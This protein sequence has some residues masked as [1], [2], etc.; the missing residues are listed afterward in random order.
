MT[1]KLLQTKTKNEVFLLEREGNVGTS[2][3]HPY[4]VE[5]K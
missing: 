4:F 1:A 5:Y 2:F 3:R